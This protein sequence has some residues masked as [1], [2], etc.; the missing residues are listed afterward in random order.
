MEDCHNFSKN[1]KKCMAR[2]S[3]HLGG[4]MYLKKVT[5]EVRTSLQEYKVW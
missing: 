3:V 5:K 1:N 2:P 4:K